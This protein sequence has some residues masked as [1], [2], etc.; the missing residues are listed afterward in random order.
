L[1]LETE[2]GI[3]S[4]GVKGARREALWGSI[5]HGLGLKLGEP[6]IILEPKD[7][8]VIN[9]NMIFSIEINKIVPKF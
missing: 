2:R 1:R 8:T 5:G 3:I 4:N 6:P 7:E 9:K